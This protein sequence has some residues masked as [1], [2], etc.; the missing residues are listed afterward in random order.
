MSTEFED[1]VSASL[2][3]IVSDVKAEPR[4]MEESVTRRVVVQS[5]R[6]KTA[7]A[8]IG[9][10]GA[11]ALAV[12]APFVVLNGDDDRTTAPASGPPAPGLIRDH[13]SSATRY[14]EHL[15]SLVQL[16]PGG[17]EVD[18]PP[19]H[20]L[21]HLFASVTLSPEPTHVSRWWIYQRSAQSVWEWVTQHKHPGLTLEETV[22]TG[23]PIPP[24]RRPRVDSVAFEPSSG[25][26]AAFVY[27]DVSVLVASIGADRTGVAVIATVEPSPHRP[28]AEQVPTAGVQAVVAWR[29]HPGGA[30]VHTTLEPDAAARLAQAFD[31]LPR[32]T[33]SYHGCPALLSE[34]DVVVTFRGGGHTWRATYSGCFDINVTRDG[35]TLPALTTSTSESTSHPPHQRKFLGELKADGIRLP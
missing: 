14:G 33:L 34:N 17:K 16:P 31:A 1:I 11:V 18:S 10:A 30:V 29:R 19:V 21:A 5:R 27:G 7:A 20:A 26:P 3:N 24:D 15:V 35:A 25:L 9:G 13:P 2:K 8:V 6:R 4:Q 32:V 12:G 28:A 22:G 23:F